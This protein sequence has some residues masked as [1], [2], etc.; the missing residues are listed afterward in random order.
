MRRNDRQRQQN[1]N[2]DADGN[3]QHRNRPRFMGFRALEEIAQSD[4]QEILI[5]VNERKDSF[6][7]LINSAIDRADIFVLIIKILSKVCQSSFDELKLKLLLDVCNSQF[8]GHLRN[9]L[10]DL[11]YA[12]VKT[13]NNVYWNNQLDFWINFVMFCECIIDLSPAT[14]LRKCRS[15]IEDTSKCCLEGLKARHG[16]NLPDNNMSKLAELR[17]RLSVCEK[18][19]VSL[20]EN[21]S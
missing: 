19:N 9:Y 7:N 14:A 17:E 12:E 5:K 10:M 8:I 11:P 18:E 6:L 13:R 2:E 21:F 1:R 4:D 15:L 16:F 20:S 3:Q